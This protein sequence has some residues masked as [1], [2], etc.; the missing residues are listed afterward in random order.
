M[1]T[2][3]YNCPCCGGP[4]NFSGESGKLECASCGNSFELEAL[5]MMNSAE[6]GEEITF[7]NTAERFGA[8][9]SGVQAYICKNCGA[10]LLA[11]ETTTAMECPYC[12]SPTILPDRIEGGV[13]P[14]KVVPFAVTKEQAQKQFEEYFKGK[15]LLPNVFLNGRNRISE[16]R[17]L[18]VPYWLFDCDAR[19]CDI[20]RGKEAHR[21]KRRMGNHPHGALRSAP[22]G[23]YAL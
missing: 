22:P 10:D 11:E 13:K 3:S 14:E 9:E 23:R 12:G 20:R 17:R 1:S 15:K 8:D 4:L 2:A 5:E 19:R 7:A 21:A 16:M 18:Y 6:S